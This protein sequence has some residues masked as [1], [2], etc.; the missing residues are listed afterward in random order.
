MLFKTYEMYTTLTDME[1]QQH[2]GLWKSLY[3]ATM[4]ILLHNFETSQQYYHRNVL[5]VDM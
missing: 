2:Y 5:S 1:S 4:R 3:N